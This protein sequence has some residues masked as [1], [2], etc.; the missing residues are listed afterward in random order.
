MGKLRVNP[1]Q[2]RK[3]FDQEGMQELTDSIAT[4]G[5]LQPLL[6]RQVGHHYEIIAGE[7]RFRA[8][9]KAG[10]TKVPVHIVTMTDQE[11]LEAALIENIIREDLS[12]IE[13]AKAFAQ[14]QKEFSLTQEEI[15]TRTGKDRSTIANL[16]RLLTLPTSIQKLVDEKKISM[17]HARALLRFGNQ[18]H[19]EILVNL[20]LEKGLSV[21]QVEQWKFHTPAKKKEKQAALSANI[22]STVED[23]QRKLGTKVLLSDEK[24][25][26]LTI[27]FHHP[28][29]LQKILSQLLK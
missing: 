18:T 6:V 20:I 22:R 16:L 24:K 9:T 1:R 13:T 25:G 19:Q 10:L 4:K 15:A 11:Q 23:I 21:R 8:S 27:A 29:E 12:A 17:G 28:G 2:P 7:R 14:L 3:H 26:K 5:V